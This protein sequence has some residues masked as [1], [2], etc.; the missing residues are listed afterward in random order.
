[1]TKDEALKAVE[2]YGSQRKAAKA[3]GVVHKSIW[4][5]IN[6][7]EDSKAGRTP[8]AQ[9]KPGKSLSE[10][11]AAYD[12]DF[13]IPQR[14]RTALKELGAGWEFEVPFAKSAGVSLADLSAYRPAFAD[15]V[16]EI[17]RDSKRAWAG[18]K[19]T[20]VSMRKML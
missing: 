12:K 13:I 8:V 10:F 1:M 5:A 6:G 4:R 17:R 14:I 3:L 9:P 18:T 20:A 15:H 7:R 11:K 16:V 19:A 2:K